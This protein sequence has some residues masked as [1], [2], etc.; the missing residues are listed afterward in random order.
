MYNSTSNTSLPHHRNP[1]SQAK[2]L[3]PAPQRIEIPNPWKP[4]I[5]THFTSTRTYIH[6]HTYTYL[7]TLP[8]P[9]NPRPRS[10]TSAPG[11]TRSTQCKGVDMP[12]CRASRTV[13]GSHSRTAEKEKREKT[14]MRGAPGPWLPT[15]PVTYLVYRYI[16][17]SQLRSRG[18]VG[19]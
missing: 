19:R 4:P 15:L 18:Q 12:A 16:P 5:N 10:G 7:I 9:Q 1:Q 2:P 13:P 3:S 6:V 8:Q 14:W 11:G 17:V